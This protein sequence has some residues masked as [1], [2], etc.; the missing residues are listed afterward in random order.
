MSI[1]PSTDLTVAA[2]FLGTRGDWVIVKPLNANYEHHV[3]LE[4]GPPPAIGKQIRGVFRGV[5]RKVYGVPSGGAFVTPILG[6]PRIVQGRVV[7]ITDRQVAIRAAGV[8]L[9]DLPDESLAIDL[10]QG[11]VAEGDMVNAVLLPGAWFEMA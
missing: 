1:Q 7:S 10:A 5:A 11:P 4:G 6:T 3:R 9:I 8:W 2:E